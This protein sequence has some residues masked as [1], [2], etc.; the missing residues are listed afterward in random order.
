MPPSLTLTERSRLARIAVDRTRRSLVARAL[1]SPVLKWRYGAPTVDELLIVPQELRTA[2]PSFAGELAQGQLGLGG[3]VASI[4]DGSIFDVAPPSEVWSRSLHGFGW[5]R[6][7]SAAGSDEDRE[8]ARDAILTWIERYP[9]RAGGVAWQPDVVGRRL[10]SWLANVPFVFEGIDSSTYDRIADS[11]GLQLVQLATRWRD[12]PDGYPRLEALIGLLTGSLCIAGRDNNVLEFER[13]IVGEIQA[14]VLADGGHISRNTNLVIE[15]LLDLL[16]LQTCFT[17]RDRKFHPELS[18]AIARL[19]RFLRYMRL[20]DGSLTRF[21]GMGATPFDSL[22]TL[23]AYDPAPESNLASAPNSG[24]A[25]LASGDMIMVVDVGTPPS[26]EH[27]GTACAGALSFEL[28]IGDEAVFVNAGSPGP[29]DQDWLATSRST[30]SHNTLCL[31]T[32]SSSKLLRNKM[33]NRLVRASPIRYPNKVAVELNKERDGAILKCT[34]DGYVRK[35]SLTHKRELFMAR[36]GSRVTGEDIIGAGT[37]SVRFA[38]DL[39]Y[40][41]HFHLDNDII[42]RHDSDP[43]A[44]ILELRNG[45]M[46]RFTARGTTLSIE[47]SINFADL[48]GPTRSSQIVLRG[49]SFGETR[50]NWALEPA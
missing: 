46:W 14:Q 24:Y 19:L 22:A 17:A 3:A 42:C 18:A 16:P 47:D 6:N 15:L 45:E 44:A 12:A 2:D 32:S 26:L 20:G 25:R 41:I 38:R 34:H 50:V 48:A 27:A 36:D 39:P 7:L 30:A 49:A 10:Q 28:S 35:F 33:L 5:L 9:P 4:G 1:R 13:A 21:N 31:N 40:A 23:L 11:L 29:S 37:G 8:M 43:A